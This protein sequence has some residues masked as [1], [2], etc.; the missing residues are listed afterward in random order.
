MEAA[1]TGGASGVAAGRSVWSEA[2]TLDLEA[3]RAF[4]QGEASGRLRRLRDLCDERARP[5]FDRLQPPDLPAE[6]HA[7]F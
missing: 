1:C 7:R 2:V 5:F 3:R 4:L 6:W